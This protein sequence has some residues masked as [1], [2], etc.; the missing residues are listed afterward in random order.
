MQQTGTDRS[1][2]VEA[3][4]HHY[5]QRQYQLS[6][7]AALKA[8]QQQPDDANTL[9]IAGLAIS[10]Q[11]RQQEAI[12]ILEHAVDIAPAEAN[13]HYNLGVLYAEAGDMERAMLAYRACLDLDEQHQGAL[14][15]YADLLRLNEHFELALAYFR[16]I[17]RWGLSLDEGHLA[18]RIGVTLHALGR[19]REAAG[20]L[21]EALR[22]GLEESAV[23][24]WEYA[25]VALHMGDYKNGWQA[26]DHRFD[27]G[28]R[29]SVTC[30]PFDYPRWKEQGLRGKTLLIHGE[31]GLGDEMMFAGVIPELIDEAEKIVL[32]CQPPLVRL[33][34][35][36]MPRLTVLPH[37]V[38]TAPAA[39]QLQSSGLAEEIDYQIPIGSLARFRR[40]SAAQ[41]PAHGGYLHADA[42]DIEMFA[43]RLRQRAPNMR[44]H[45]R[46]GL[47]WG[48]NPATETGWGARRSQ[49]KSIPVPE[50]APLAAANGKLL[51]V[52]LQNHERGHEAALAPELGLIDFSRFLTDMADTAALIA[53]LDLVITVDTSI[54][55]LAGAMGIPTWV[56][57][58][59]RCDWRW[60]RDTGKSPWYPSVR[61]FRQPRQGAWQP[62]VEEITE[63]LDLHIQEAASR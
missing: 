43:E 23:T 51:F 34:R 27:A 17:R 50:L 11:G 63:A 60:L 6:E 53:N 29:T 47:M 35:N 9:L 18:H 32:A 48:A 56:M 4:L 21:R 57:L 12:A 61:L 22:S 26:Y 39:R 16:K 25:H 49:Q 20:V 52:S 55:H 1:H 3:A 14:W 36:S 7:A 8:L 10:N 62:V 5:R 40:D 44:E 31:Q 42:A 30:H 45:F 54:A 24:C 58:M 46:V 15:N 19:D 59:E 2:W 33:F 41:F 28:Y 13:I 38:V 37:R